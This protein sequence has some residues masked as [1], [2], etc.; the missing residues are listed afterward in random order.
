MKYFLTL[1]FSCLI[2]IIHGQ[3]VYIYDGYQ[4]NR[5]IELLDLKYEN[6]TSFFTSIRNQNSAELVNALYQEYNNLNGYEKQVAQRILQQY[7]YFTNRS[8]VI[9]KASSDS[10]FHY[11]DN[12]ED[13]EFSVKKGE[14]IG[15]YFY[16]NLHHFY[17]VESDK[18]AL[19][20][21]PLLNINFANTS[22]RSELLYQ[23]TRGARISG[24]VDKKVYFF[25]EVLE[26]Q[27]NFPTYVNEYI[28]EN[29]AIPG[30]GFYK[31]FESDILESERAYDYL[32]ARGY[33]GIPI[34]K[35]IALDIGH[36]R[37]FIGE[38]HRSLLL[39]DLFQQLFLFEAQYQNLEI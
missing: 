34:S 2:I 26:N 9:K 10:S 17:S 33:L 1:V 8:E 25:S 4:T 3:G 37:H 13:I 6:Q 31:A 18:F 7:H 29:K 28:G 35:S 22:D 38:G 12:P 14:G 15:K 11:F 16:N 36:G 21:D 23:N 5:T 20:V 30:N 24:Y 32:N 19:H 27:S 39:S